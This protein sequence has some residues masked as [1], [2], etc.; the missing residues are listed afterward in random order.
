MASS[1]W[2]DSLPSKRIKVIE[3]LVQGQKLTNRLLG[4]LRQSEKSMSNDQT[5]VDDV[6]VQILKMFDS[7]LAILSS[8]TF[9]EIPR[10]ETKYLSNSNAQNTEHTD[11]SVQIITPVKP[12]R[13]CHKRRKGSWTSTKI[14]SA[15][16]DDG[17]AWRKY[18]QKVILNKKHKRNYYRCTYKFDQGCHATKQVQK[19]EDNP[20]KYKTIY[21]GQHT[22]NIL[23]RTIPHQII[24][25]SSHHPKDNSVLLNFAI[26]GLTNN[27]NYNNQVD[28]SPDLRHRQKSSLNHCLLWNRTKQVTQAISKPIS[29]TMSSGLDN[30]EDMVSLGVCSSA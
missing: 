27:N 9:N 24:L 8:C 15:L 21:D 28:L 1:S 5:S 13:G 6:A 29:M 2:P 10:G 30:H 3:Y 14:T 19:I 25:D 11:E 16:V 22:C 26:E 7:T 20:P 4:M 18:G 17:Y 12:K 23:R